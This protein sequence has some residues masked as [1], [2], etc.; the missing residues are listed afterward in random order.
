MLQSYR[1][2]TVGLASHWPCGQVTECPHSHSYEHPACGPLPFSPL[3]GTSLS[4]KP[5]FLVSSPVECYTA[6]VLQT[7]TTLFLTN[8]CVVFNVVWLCS[9]WSWFNHFLSAGLALR[10]SVFFVA[11]S[12]VKKVYV[13][14]AACLCIGF[15]HCLSD[16]YHML[17]RFLD[18]LSSSAI[19]P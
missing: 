15:C 1:E 5:S 3:F 6:F 4:G 12:L 18:Q 7:N 14:Y 11:T 2:V 9:V 17:G 8:V 10:L 13:C 16:Q 19:S